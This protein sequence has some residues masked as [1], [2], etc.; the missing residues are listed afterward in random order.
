MFRAREQLRR[1]P[2]PSGGTL[3]DSVNA[4]VESRRSEEPTLALAWEY[5]GE[6]HRAGVFV[7]ALAS[8]FSLGEETLDA[9]FREA[10][11][12]TA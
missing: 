6:V 11:T 5:A 8:V 12:I 1:T 9:L 10:A 3:L 7:A 2:A 4:Y